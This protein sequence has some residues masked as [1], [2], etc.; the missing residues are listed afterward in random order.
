MAFKEIIN[1]YSWNEISARIASK[2]KAEVENALS[3]AGL[4]ID[5]FMALVSPAAET[6]LEQMAQLSHQ[7]TRYRFGNTIQLYIPLYLSNAC[8]NHCLYCGFNHTNNIRRI[9]LT[10]SEIIKEVEAIKQIAPFEHILLVTGES[11][12]DAGVEYLEKAIRLVKP[13]FSSISIEV[14]P[15]RK[16]EYKRLIEA[17]LNSVMCYQETY[18]K[19]TYPNYHP[20]GKKHFFDWRVDTFDR[21]GCAGIHKM[22]LGVLLGL[23]DWRTDA[24]FVALHLR[25]LQKEYWKT[26]YSISFPRIRPHI[27]NPFQP[28]APVNERN[29]AQ[30]IFAFRIFDH[31]LELPLS[32]RESPNFRDH[33]VALGITSLSANSKTDPGG[34]ASY[35]AA[36]E[37]FSVNDNRTAHEI[38]AVVRKTGLEVVWKDWELVLQG[39]VGAI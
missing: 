35:P 8:V 7:L 25:Y 6:Y 12:H 33:A 19:E 28:K 31:D 16:E 9:V 30:L 11:P 5:D 1:N 2:T 38:A 27:G 36:P 32:T 39:S 4:S 22:G 24:T 13:H 15:L 23:E 18:N 29:L 34:Y 20:R 14:Q 21:M 37:Q 17:G 26:K 3:K 10:G